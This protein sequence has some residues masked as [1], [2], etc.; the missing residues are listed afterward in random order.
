MP[1]WLY[2]KEN[3]EARIRNGRPA[4]ENPSYLRLGEIEISDSIFQH[5]TMNEWASAAHVKALLKALTNTGNPF[6]PLVV[7]WAGDGWVGGRPPPLQGLP[8]IRVRRA[9]PS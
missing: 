7:L 2:D 1:N 8:G 4:P 3:L 9:S 5:R 6:E